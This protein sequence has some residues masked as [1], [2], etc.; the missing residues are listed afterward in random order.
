M[1]YFLLEV[2]FV[3]HEVD[4]YVSGDERE[5]ETERVLV[6]AE[7]FSEAV[8]KAEDYYKDNLE[9]FGKIDIICTEF[10]AEQDVLPVATFLSYIKEN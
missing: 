9:R 10:G 7:S 5:I 6:A 1:F 3:A 4:P 2:D 8:S